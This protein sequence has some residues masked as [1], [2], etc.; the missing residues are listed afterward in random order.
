MKFKYFSVKIQITIFL[1]LFFSSNIFINSQTSFRKNSHL[2]FVEDKEKKTYSCFG[3]YIKSFETD[4]IYSMISDYNAKLIAINTDK[5]YNIIWV[6]IIK[7][8]FFFIT[9]H[10]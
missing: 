4:H 5:I 8:E 10:I 1:L 6:K 2:F 7:N 9:R 3:E